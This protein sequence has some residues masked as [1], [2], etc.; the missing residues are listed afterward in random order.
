MSFA[1]S[2]PTRAAASTPEPVLVVIK[3]Y[4]DELSAM[5]RCHDNSKWMDLRA[6]KG[7]ATRTQSGHEEI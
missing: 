1:R 6:R 5:E 2:S 3:G 4:A 7:L